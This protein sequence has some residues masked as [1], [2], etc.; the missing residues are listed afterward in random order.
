MMRIG[1]GQAEVIDTK[2]V[3]DQVLSVCQ[4]QMKGLSAQAGIVFSSIN[5]DHQ[6]ML[7]HIHDAFPGMALIGCTTAGDFSSALGFSDDSIN[8]VII[9]IKKE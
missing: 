7:N 6:L 1:L 9:K 8:L 2:R 3:T 5:Y 4:S